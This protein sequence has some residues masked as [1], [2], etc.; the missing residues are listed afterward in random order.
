MKLVFTHPFEAGHTMDM[1][2][3]FMEHYMTKYFQEEIGIGREDQ[4]KGNLFLST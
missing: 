1:G 2:I 3:F 4:A